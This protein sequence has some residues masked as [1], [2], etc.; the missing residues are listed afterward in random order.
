MLEGKDV[1]QRLFKVWGT[2]QHGFKPDGMG[3]LDDASQHAKITSIALDA[4]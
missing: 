4:A 2:A 3:F 1:V